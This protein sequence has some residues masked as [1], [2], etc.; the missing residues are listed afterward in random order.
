M[1]HPHQVDAE[2]RGF[3]VHGAAGVGGGQSCAGDGVRATSGTS[4]VLELVELSV[5]QGQ[6]K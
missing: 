1:Q 3:H 4:R 6:V 5:V 2:A